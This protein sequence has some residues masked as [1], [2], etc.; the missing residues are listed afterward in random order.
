M[1]ALLLPEYWGW[2]L[3]VSSDFSGSNSLPVPSPSNIYTH[4]HFH[5]MRPYLHVSSSVP[6]VT[7]NDGGPTPAA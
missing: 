1:V 4:S 2:G 6:M 3:S 7:M 5:C